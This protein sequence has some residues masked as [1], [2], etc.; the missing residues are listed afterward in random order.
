MPGQKKIQRAPKLH[1]K[2]QTAGVATGGV[3]VRFRAHQY[4]TRHIGIFFRY[5]EIARAQT[6]P[7]WRQVL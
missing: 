3:N 2:R 6:L 5:G 7:T 1:W 4:G